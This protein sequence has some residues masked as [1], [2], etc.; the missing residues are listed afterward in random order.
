MTCIGAP[1]SYSYY[2]ND[3]VT[4]ESL[5]PFDPKAP[6]DLNCRSARQHMG[7]MYR[8]VMAMF[9]VKLVGA[10]ISV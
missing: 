10:I 9:A 5:S 2:R 6:H 7:M 4:T 1:E 3:I 8:M